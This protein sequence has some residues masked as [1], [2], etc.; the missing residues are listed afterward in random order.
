MKETQYQKNGRLEMQRN[1]NPVKY[2]LIKEGVKIVKAFVDL[3]AAKL[4]LSKND[5]CKMCAAWYQDNKAMLKDTKLKS[6]SK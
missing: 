3:A 6:V 4:F 1:P 5:H 2:F